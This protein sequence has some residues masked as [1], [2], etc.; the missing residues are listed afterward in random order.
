MPYTVLTYARTLIMRISR[1]W[2][3]LTGRAAGFS[4]EARIFH[5]ISLGIVL[6]AWCYV[7]Y[8]LFAG[9]YVAAAS[10]VII[11]GFFLYEYYRSRYCGHPHRSFIFGFVGLALFSVNYFCNS[12]INGS[13]DL[14]WPVYLLLLLT[15]CPYRHHIGWV[16]TYLVVF[17]LVHLLEHLHPEL[18]HYPF[19]PGKGQFIDR[20][21][22][23]PMP[24]LGMAVVIGLFRRSYDRERAKAE[25][26]NIEKSRLLSILSHDFRAPLIQIR[27]YLELLND[28]ELSVAER[29]Q[30]EHTL[31]KA[32]D[33][34][35]DMVT[36]LLHWSR[37]QLDG[38]AVHLTRLHLAET[39]DSTLSIQ[40]G[41]AA[42][43]Q[44][45]IETYINPAIQILGDADM[46]QLVVRNLLQNAIKFTPKN[47][48][49]SVSTD[50]NETYCQ[51]HVSD[52]GTGITPN[53]LASLFSGDIV[54]A[55]GTANE[56]GVGLGLILCREFMERQGGRIS[57]ESTLGKG[58]VFT[59]ELP[60]VQTATA[61]ATD[62]KIVP[63]QSKV[64]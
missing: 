47:G 64:A 51:L 56:K 42:Q 46:L 31:R 4:L 8:D 37:S 48:L 17:G 28:P 5:S 33:Q 6:L 41:M 35:L 49:I 32:N 40:K 54:P 3:V 30:L 63:F 15:I 26:R 19:R 44:V 62:A 18:V 43:K 25:Q 34:T 1:Q 52:S 29:A 50:V 45:E 22:A 7:P 20:I 11:S 55:Y 38:A 58:S 16:I 39:L 23:F 2:H 59:I 36:N 53:Q 12:G 10:C 27:Q 9:L 60:L 57:V 21:T 24:V 14:I 61:P 13:T